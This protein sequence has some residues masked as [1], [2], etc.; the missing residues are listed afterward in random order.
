VLAVRAVLEFIFWCLGVQ[1]EVVFVA[2]IVCGC[3]L[4]IRES[5]AEWKE[6]VM[7]RRRNVG[8]VTCVVESCTKYLKKVTKGIINNVQRWIRGICKLFDALAPLS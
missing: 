1:T 2:H 6:S 3:Q 8:N 4:A 7:Y 5:G